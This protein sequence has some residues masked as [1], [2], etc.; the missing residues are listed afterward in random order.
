MF[1][2]SVGNSAKES[3]ASIR[4]DLFAYC[5]KVSESDEAS[6]IIVNKIECALDGETT[7]FGWRFLL[8]LILVRRTADLMLSYELDYDKYLPL[9]LSYRSVWA[10]PVFRG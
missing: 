4:I 10:P 2:T 6:L 3:S 9:L 1:T 5:T 7:K 8:S